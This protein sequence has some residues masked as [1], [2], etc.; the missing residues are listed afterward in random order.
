MK[1]FQDYYLYFENGFRYIFEKWDRVSPRFFEHLQLTGL[2]LL[3][4]FLIALPVG[5]LISR[6]RWLAGPVLGF[7]GILY[8]IPSLAFLAFLVPIFGIYPTTTI[9]V[10]IAYSQTLLVRNITLGFT[11]IDG[12]ILEAARGMGM[13]SAQVFW[14]VEAPLALPVILAGLR[15]TTLSII[16]IAT[17]GAWAG[18]GGLGLLLKVD[19]PRLNSAGIICV[20]FIAL[21]ADQLYRQIE[22][23]V[24]AYRTKKVSPKRP[25]PLSG[26]S[27]A[28]SESQ[29]VKV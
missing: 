3:I 7:L 22:N 11:G 29:P 16:S 21:V 18:A 9:I 15:I 8:T 12:S 10:L 14:K 1:F 6:V 25:R 20:V 23:L 19:N 5:F 26:S 24:G 4:G 13:S 27:T 28:G 2:S 17:V